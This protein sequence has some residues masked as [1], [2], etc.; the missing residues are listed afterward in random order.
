MPVAW[1]GSTM[2]GRCDQLMQHGHSREV[3]RV[4]RVIIKRADAA[5][6][7]DDLLVAARP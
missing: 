1:L 5:F 7:E 2:T 6:A 3:E 4:A